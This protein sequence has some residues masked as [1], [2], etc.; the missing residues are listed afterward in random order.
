MTG[1]SYLVASQLEK[2][3]EVASANVVKEGSVSYVDVVLADDYKALQTRIENFEYKEPPV[4]A[5]IR[6]ADRGQHQTGIVRSR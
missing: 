2:R 1:T 6:L 5:D 4:D 3:P